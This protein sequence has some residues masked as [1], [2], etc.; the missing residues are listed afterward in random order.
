[1]CR[2]VTDYARYFVS[3]SGARGLMGAAALLG[4]LDDPDFFDTV[5]VLCDEDFYE[6][7]MWDD[8]EDEANG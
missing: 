6:D 5:F 2:D 4:K 1:M 8:D 7:S 3:E